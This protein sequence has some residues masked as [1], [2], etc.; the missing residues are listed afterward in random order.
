[1]HFK[2]KVKKKRAAVEETLDEETDARR[3]D[4]RSIN[5]LID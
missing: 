1:M 3:G 2:F 4:A 5:R